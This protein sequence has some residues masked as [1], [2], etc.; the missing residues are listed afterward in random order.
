M[1][2]DIVQD[3]QELARIL[4]R[5]E[6]QA[7]GDAAAR[8]ESNL[9]S[10]FLRYVW[11]QL[12]DLLPEQAPSP[13]AMDA[14]SWFILA[15]VVIALFIVIV[16]L[17]R[18]YVYRSRLAR[19]P[20]M[21]DEEKSQS[22]GYYLGEAERLMQ[23]GELREATRCMFLAFLLHAQAAGWIRL[24]KWKTNGEYA[25]ELRVKQA[26]LLPLFMNGAKLFDR[27]WYGGEA[28]DSEQCR[29]LYND[30]AALGGQ[31]GSL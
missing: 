11:E 24:E 25:S 8:E 19:V 6:F 27:V 17:A 1:P 20:V 7:H 18:Q 13:G 23:Q 29:Q 12:K 9:L 4:E 31:E 28:A 26:A 22:P 21:S 2:S 30:I 10:R 3:K 15:A 5:S 16:W 14:V